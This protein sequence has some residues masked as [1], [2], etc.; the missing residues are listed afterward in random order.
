VSELGLD[1]ADLED[2]PLGHDQGDGP[3]VPVVAMT[4]CV[5]NLRLRAHMMGLGD[6]QGS[7]TCPLPQQQVL[8]GGARCW[9]RVRGIC[10]V[11]PVTGGSRRRVLFAYSFG[12]ARVTVGPNDIFA[13]FGWA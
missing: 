9:A 1:I 2:A 6:M 4:V 11:L 8:G 5:S 7:G 12:L 3:Q 10:P 13:V